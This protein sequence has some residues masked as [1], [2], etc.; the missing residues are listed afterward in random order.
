MILNVM[1]AIV[2]DGVIKNTEPVLLNGLAL[3]PSDSL[4]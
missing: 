1:Y 3:C 2:I 4:L